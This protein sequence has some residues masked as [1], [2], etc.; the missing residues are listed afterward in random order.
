MCGIPIFKGTP[1]KEQVMQWMLLNQN[2]FK[3]E[4]KKNSEK[5]REHYYD[6]SDSWVIARAGLHM[7]KNKSI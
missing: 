1:A 4:K 3:V 5:I 7:I 2:W 6:M